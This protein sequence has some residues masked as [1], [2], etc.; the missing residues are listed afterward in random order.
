MT[1]PVIDFRDPTSPGTPLASLT[2]T[3]SGA[4]G[5]ITAGTTSSVATIRI[6]N[7][8]TQT[9]GISD[10]LNCVLAVYD[11]AASQY[12]GQAITNPTSQTWMQL[13]IVDFC[14][15]TN[16]GDYDLTNNA[17]FYP[18]GGS[19]KHAFSINGGSLNGSALGNPASPLVPTAIAG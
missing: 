16:G 4:G 1:Q 14:G 10:A 8:Y 19:T 12:Q 7:N 5:A 15:A 11:G 2:I 9:N 17:I 6:Y 18:V 3:G 13:S